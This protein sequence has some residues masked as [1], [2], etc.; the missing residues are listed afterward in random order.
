[1]AENFIAEFIQLL[2]TNYFVTFLPDWLFLNLGAYSLIAV[3]FLVERKFVGRIGVFSNT[4][5]LN[6]FFSQLDKPVNF[7]PLFST[8]LTVYLNIGLI[9]GCVALLFYAT[10]TSF[11]GWV[12]KLAWAYSSIVAGV[13]ILIGNGVL[14]V[15]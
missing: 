3:G 10:N 12:Y 5:A 14:L 1:M 8:L 2:Q 4:I 9:F 15:N 11:K 6:L 7:S 13:L